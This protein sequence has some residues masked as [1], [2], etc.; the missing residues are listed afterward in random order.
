[1]NELSNIY[2]HLGYDDNYGDD[3]YNYNYKQ[4]QQ[5]ANNIP[6]TVAPVTHVPNTQPKEVTEPEQNY[7][8][9]KTNTYVFLIC[10]ILLYILVVNVFTFIIRNACRYTIGNDRNNGS[11]PIL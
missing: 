4:K 3:Y 1:M 6:Y 10:L 7:I 11:L 8:C 5:M 9:I 2:P